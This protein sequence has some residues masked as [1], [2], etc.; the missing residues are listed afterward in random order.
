M[1]KL[2]HIP[3]KIYLPLLGLVLVLAAGLAYRQIWH[4]SA[5][6]AESVV[7]EA[8]YVSFN[9]GYLFS[10]PAR[11]VAN[12]TAIAGVTIAYPES[13]P[14][15]SGKKLEELYT[16]GAVA[17]QLITQLKDDNEQAFKDYVNNTLAADLRKTLNSASDVRE[18][19]RG[20]IYA[21]EVFALDNSGAH[22]RVAAAINFPQPVL[23]TA[24]NDNEPFKTIFSTTEDLRKSKLKPDIDHAAQAAKSVADML[25]RQDASGIRDK[26]TTD[27]NKN[28]TKNQ[29]VANL[30]LSAT[31]LDR[32]ITVVGGTYD[33]KVFIAQLAFEPKTTDKVPVSGVMSLSKQGKNW[34]LDGFQLPQ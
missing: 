3:R 1:K 7:V 32:K 17:V 33:G 16:T 8:K 6:P 22:L 5:K 15:P 31:Y 24:A 4:K 25:Y 34:E 11:Y 2:Q 19:S 29:L 30:S 13:Q 23:I 9:G 27:F 12:E 14:M 10:I 20:S 18:A 21:K 28:V 26:S